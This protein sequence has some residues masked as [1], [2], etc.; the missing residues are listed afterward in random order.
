MIILTPMWGRLVTCGRLSTGPV[1]RPINNRPQVA[2]LP[3]NLEVS[4]Q[5]IMRVSLCVLILVAAV[6]GQPSYAPPNDAPNPYMTVTGWAQL[7]D[8]RKWGSTAGVE[9]GPDGHIW[10]YDRCGANS[11]AD[12]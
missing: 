5:L 3:H 12:S 8:G 7:P 1:R 10:A 11:C 6:N 9:I 2:N 4:M